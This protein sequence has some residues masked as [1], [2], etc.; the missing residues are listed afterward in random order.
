MNVHE[1]YLVV[2][3][4]LIGYESYSLLMGMS[5]WQKD[6]PATGHIDMLINAAD[7]MNFP[8]EKSK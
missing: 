6:Y 8:L 2:P 5:G 3:M 7:S 4:R 1:N